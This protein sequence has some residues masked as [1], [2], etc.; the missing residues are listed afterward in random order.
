MNLQKLFVLKIQDL[1]MKLKNESKLHLQKLFTISF[2][3]YIL[4]EKYIF[5][6]YNLPLHLVTF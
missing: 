1:L 4:V 5:N 3:N 2:L 6:L